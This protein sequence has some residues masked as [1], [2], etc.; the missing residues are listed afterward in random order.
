MGMMKTLKFRQ[1]AALCAA[2]LFLA[3]CASVPYTGRKQFNVVSEAEE[4]KLGEQA[5]QEV[6]AKTP[7]SKNEEYQRRVRA[8]GAR[9]KAAADKP[10]FKWEFNV[11]AGKEIN[12]F[13]LPGGKVAFWEAILPL[14]ETDAGIAVVMGH[15][16]AHALAHHGAERMSEGMGANIIG[17]IISVGLG[18]ADPARRDSV[19]QL[20]GIGS[21]VGIMLPFSRTHESEADKIGL[22]LMAKAG[23][24]PRAAVGFWERMAASGGQKPPEL[25]STHP[26]DATRIA[27]IRK[28]LPEA[29]TYYKPGE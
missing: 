17:E 22:I 28:W 2:A 16:V 26:A 15:E 6:L 9:I 19:L 24:D 8:V 3:A 29:L 13:C 1:L 21:Q 12:A 18:N 25:L 5:Y 4:I 7:L 27:Q 14:C 20:Y 11:L 10:D 23:Y